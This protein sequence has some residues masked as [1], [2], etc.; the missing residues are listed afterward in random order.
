MRAGVQVID[1]QGL[2]ITTEARTIK[3]VYDA[4]EGSEKA[5]CLENYKRGE[6]EGKACICNAKTNGTDFNAITTVAVNGDTATIEYLK[7]TDT[8]TVQLLTITK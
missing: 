6:V 1:C 3:G 7:V 4:I 8:D 2:D 5:L